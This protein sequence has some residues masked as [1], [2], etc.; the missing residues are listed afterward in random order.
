MAAI[1]NFVDH[2][3]H[4]RAGDVGDGAVAPAGNELAA[5]AQPDGIGGASSRNVPADEVF[6][7]DI[8]SA[9]LLRGRD[10]LFRGLAL[11]RVGTVLQF[12]QQSAPTVARLGQR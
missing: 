4:V 2:A 3:N 5:D 10:P 8:E 7:D 12:T 6:G 1:G 11:A 9:C